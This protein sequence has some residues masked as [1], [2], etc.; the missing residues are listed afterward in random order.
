[1]TRLGSPFPTCSNSIS[2]TQELRQLW[3]SE[4]Y[5]ALLAW[6]SS[7][8]SIHWQR[9][10]GQ[11]TLP[12]W[13]FHLLMRFLCG[14][15]ETWNLHS[16]LGRLFSP[17]FLMIWEQIGNVCGIFLSTSSEKNWEQFWESFT[18]KSFTVKEGLVWSQSLNHS[19]TVTRTVHSFG[20]YIYF[21]NVHFLQVFDPAL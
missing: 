2:P 10:L 18:V 1:M 6:M 16:T 7:N 13:A 15:N 9:E 3:C 19:F 8:F 12:L 5:S 14:S 4:R 17:F 11:V 20:T 21:S